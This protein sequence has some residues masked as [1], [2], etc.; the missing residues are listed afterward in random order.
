MCGQILDVNMVNEP[1]AHVTKL[2]AQKRKDKDVPAQVLG[3]YVSSLGTI[4][5]VN[6][7]KKEHLRVTF[8]VSVITVNNKKYFFQ[9]YI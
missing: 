7:R 1:K 4:V 2:K 3:Y 8:E 6:W 5:Q 9:N